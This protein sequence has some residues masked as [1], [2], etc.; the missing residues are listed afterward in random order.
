[1]RPSGVSGWLRAARRGLLLIACACVGAVGLY[2]LAQPLFA[3]S[4]APADVASLAF[5][6]PLSPSGAGPVVKVEIAVSECD[7][8]VSVHALLQPTA[9]YWTS[10][11]GDLEHLAP[12][13]LV[14]G[15]VRTRNLELGPA[16]L[17]DP[18]LHNHLVQ[19]SL[20]AAPRGSVRVLRQESLANGALGIATMRDWSRTRVPLVANFEAELVSGTAYGECVLQVPEMVGSDLNNLV[21]A[22][23]DQLNPPDKPAFVTRVSSFRSASQIASLGQVEIAGTSVAVTDSPNVFVRTPFGGFVA[24]EPPPAANGPH[25]QRSSLSAGIFTESIGEIRATGR[26]AAGCASNLAMSTAGRNA[27]YSFWLLLAGG[28]LSGIVALFGAGIA[29]L[30]RAWWREGGSVSI[31]TT[32]S[33]SAT[34]LVR[35]SADRAD[36]AD[37]G[38]ILGAVAVLLLLWRVW[39][40]RR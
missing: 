4:P 18:L 10:F 1:V 30:W 5:S 22:A 9:E 12:V 39:R 23:A 20:P 31:S 7:R 35:T 36:R 33:D 38:K 28:A 19:T 34:A 13:A 8:W 15:G 37:E 40:R 6:V 21:F 16:S 24:C 25:I 26:P 3:T 32:S 11:H 14:V 27:Y 17:T 29:S 2:C